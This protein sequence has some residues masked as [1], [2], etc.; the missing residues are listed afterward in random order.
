[1]KQKT[2]RSAA[3]FVMAVGLIMAL[4]APAAA[5]TNHVVGGWVPRHRR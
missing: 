1:M 4:S 2:A 5:A 3:M